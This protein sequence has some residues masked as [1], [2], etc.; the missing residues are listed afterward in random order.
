M[1]LLSVA[2]AGCGT[3]SATVA[4]PISVSP[5]SVSPKSVPTAQAGFA[6]YKWAVVAVASG[7]KQTPVPLRYN[8]YLQFAPNGEFGANE[9]VNFHFGTY[10]LTGDGFT[11]SQSGT[12]AA[13]YAGHDPVVLLTQDAITVAFGVASH[14]TATVTGDRLSVAVAG[15]TLICQRDGRQANFPT[16]SPT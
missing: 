7:G 15:Y 4:P 9:P 3:T 1:A 10:R 12:T 5:I 13:A 2:A 11:T 14:A 8:V 6:V 16:P